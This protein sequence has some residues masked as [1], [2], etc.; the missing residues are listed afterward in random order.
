MKS[1][2]EN[3][4]PGDKN[5]TRE[6]RE[7][8]L[9][10]LKALVAVSAGAIWGARKIWKANETSAFLG[11]IVNKKEYAEYQE[12][13]TLGILAEKMQSVYNAM[14]EVEEAGLIKSNEEDEIEID[15]ENADWDRIFQREKSK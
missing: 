5:E 11:R 4:T 15:W 10:G 8:G 1:N 7:I 9:K 2:I 3:L 13:G 12:K 6:D 14:S